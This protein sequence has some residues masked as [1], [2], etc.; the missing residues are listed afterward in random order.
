MDR[1][2]GTYRNGKVV[3]D[4]SVDWPDGML[5]QVECASSKQADAGLESV[6]LCVDGSAWEDTPDG[7]QR[8]VERLDSLGPVLTGE[9]RERFETD[10]R[11]VPRLTVV[12]WSQQ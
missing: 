6:D 2:T 1:V 4:Q 8:W 11:A 5:V 12:D 10:L 3:L 7:R 9:E